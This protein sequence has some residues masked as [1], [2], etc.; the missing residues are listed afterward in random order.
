MWKSRV[1]NYF[2]LEIYLIWNP[3]IWLADTIL[4]QYDCEKQTNR[5]TDF[6]FG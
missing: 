2:V 1:F 6:T 3:T 4:A 5:F